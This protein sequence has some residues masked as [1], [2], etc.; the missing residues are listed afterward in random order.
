MIGSGPVRKDTSTLTVLPSVSAADLAQVETFFENFKLF[1]EN[2]LTFLQFFRRQKDSC[3]QS[4]SMPGTEDWNAELAEGS[5]GRGEKTKMLFKAEAAD[6][7]MKEI[8]EARNRKTS[9]TNRNLNQRI[10]KSRA[11]LT[12]LGEHA[13]S[14]D[15]GA[16]RTCLP[17]AAS[18][19]R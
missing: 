16:F 2:A 15:V 10:Y 12:A 17:K 3:F 8:R 9:H 11:M 19:A 5:R 6:D 4:D 13:A 14:F 18:M 7:A 1:Q